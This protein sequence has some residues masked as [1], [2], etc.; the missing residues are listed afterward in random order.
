MH[1][2]GMKLFLVYEESSGKSSP[3]KSMRSI[4]RGYDF[5]LCAYNYAYAC[6]MNR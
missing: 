3:N 4:S 6:V 2:N 1:V 5:I